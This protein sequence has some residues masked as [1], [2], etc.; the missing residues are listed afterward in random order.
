MFETIPHSRRIEEENGKKLK[1][2]FGGS[3]YS[4]FGSAFQLYLRRCSSFRHIHIILFFSS[5]ILRFLRC[6][7]KLMCQRA[8][9]IKNSQQKL[10]FIFVLV[11]FVKVASSI[12]SDSFIVVFYFRSVSSMPVLRA[13]LRVSC[14]IILLLL[15][16]VFDTYFIVNRIIDIFILLRRLL[17]VFF[18]EIISQLGRNPE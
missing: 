11:V 3:M 10:P 6:Q 14:F 2:V 16:I 5:R 13:W 15:S 18:M 8:E 7:S 9:C 17:Q 4:V 1:T 12:H